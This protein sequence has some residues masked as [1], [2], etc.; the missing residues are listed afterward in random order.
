MRNSNIKK[1]CVSAI[2]LALAYVLS[3]VKFYEMPNGGAITLLSMLPIC[4][5]SIKYGLGWGLG[6]S[7]CYSLNQLFVDLPKAMG[8]GLTPQAWIGMILFDYVVAFTVLGLAGVFRKQGRVGFCLG[9]GM[10]LV[11]RYLSSV[12]SGAVV[13]QSVGEVIGLSFENAWLFSLVYN[14]VYMVPEIILTVA[15]ALIISAFPQIK[16]IITPEN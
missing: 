16:T 12:L 8:W 9:C 2:M 15:A 14:A 10:A 7:F 13:W 3:Y 1:L 5:V 6:T 4:L 11:L